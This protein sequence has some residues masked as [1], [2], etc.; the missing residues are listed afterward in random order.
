VKQ[1]TLFWLSNLLFA[2]GLSRASVAAF[3]LSRMGVVTRFPEG[4]GARHSPHLHHRCFAD[5]P[6][7]I[8][9]S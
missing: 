1:F 4:E 2:F 6:D 8:S 5:P 7:V 9:N 3:F